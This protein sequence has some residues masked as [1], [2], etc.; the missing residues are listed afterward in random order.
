MKQITTKI[1]DDLKTGR[2]YTV[3]LAIL[4]SALLFC[5]RLFG[6][7][8]PEPGKPDWTHKFQ[9][10]LWAVLLVELLRVKAAADAITPK[11]DGLNAS[12]DYMRSMVNPGGH[13]PAVTGYPQ[14]MNELIL[15]R[16]DIRI[17]TVTC[18]QTKFVYLDDY[19]KHLETG[20]CLKIL[21]VKPCDSVFENVCFF[22]EDGNKNDAMKV[23]HANML[24]SLK[25]RWKK[26]IEEKR[27]EIRQLPQ[28]P[29]YRLVIATDK[30]N[31][32]SILWLPRPLQVT[33]RRFP[34]CH[35]REDDHSEWIEYFEKQFDT[36]WEKGEAI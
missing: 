18:S 14:D 35:L 8:E 2:N 7:F 3:Y 1:W 26:H 32:R 4:G 15:N 10:I 17:L 16:C 27:L 20:G 31:K 9:L 5:I 30:H 19:T 25:A 36:L 33:G 23:N 6:W 28:V 22:G 24:E 11:L 34:A 12:L 21:T 29:P 13:L